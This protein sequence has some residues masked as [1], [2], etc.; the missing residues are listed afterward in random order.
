MLPLLILLPGL[1]FAQQ[2]IPRHPD[3]LHITDFRQR[4]PRDGAPA[5]HSTQAWI[6]RD[7]THIHV[8]VLAAAP[9]GSLRANLNP[10]DQ[11][12][13]DDA[14]GLYLDTFHDRRRAYVFFVNPLGVQMDGIT[15]EDQ[16]DDYSFDTVWQSGGHL[17]PTGFEVWIR[18]PLR[19]LRYNAGPQATWGIALTRYTAATGEIDTWPYLSR[20][21]QGFVPHFLTS[22]APLLKPA[23]YTLRFV[24]YAAVRQDRQRELRTGADLQLSFEG[25]M[26]LDFTI[27]PDFSHVESDS[28]QPTRNQRFENFYPERRSFFLE[29]ADLF[30]TP[31]TAFFSRRLQAPKVGARFTS[32]G[33]AWKFAVLGVQDENSSTATVARLRRDFGTRGSVG[34]FFSKLDQSTLTAV[35]ATWRF[36]NHIS[37][38]NQILKENG[39]ATFSE[40]RFQSRNF[41]AHSAYRYRGPNFTAPLGYMPRNDLRQLRNG[42]SYRFRPTQ[43][44]LLAWGPDLD[45]VQ[46]RDAAGRLTDWSL[47]LPFW[48]VFRNQRELILTRQERFELYGPVRLRTHRH[49]IYFSDEHSRRL[50]YSV[51]FARGGEINYYPTPQAGLATA[52]TLGLTSR[53][54]ART[55]IEAYFIHNRIRDLYSERLWRIKA[56][57]QVT[58]NLSLRAISDAHNKDLLL[59]YQTTPFTALYVGYTQYT[60]PV[61]DHVLYT[62]FSWLLT[63]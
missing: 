54:N 29:H 35:D 45:T 32:G 41:H 27:N 28:P 31:E 19:S 40:I 14:I 60:F 24:P 61:R 3:S 30:Q 36:S 5:S 63:R 10:R 20:A 2:N 55:R 47:S 4:E 37:T 52:Y 43:G 38:A 26:S 48:F 62:K 6:S 25:R 53:P 57:R 59:R 16:D 7:D 15:A 33:P 56:S 1:L 9:A 51:S 8:R 18:I 46:T 23:N 44:P 42:A 12:S 22:A 50:G 21:H 58:R 17:T 34:G 39:L 13:G 11:L 49:S